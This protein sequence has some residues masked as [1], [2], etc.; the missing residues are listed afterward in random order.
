MLWS[1]IL[2]LA[3]GVPVRAEEL[4][5]DV[6]CGPTRSRNGRGS[7][8]CALRA[9]VPEVCRHI[10][11]RRLLGVGDQRRVR[12]VVFLSRAEG[13]TRSDSTR[14]GRISSIEDQPIRG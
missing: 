4:I 12:D 6:V 2:I 1:D 9:P 13:L 5:D 8:A 10:R 11:W 7:S 3:P 14:T